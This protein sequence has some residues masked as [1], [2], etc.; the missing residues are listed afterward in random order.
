MPQY[1]SSSTYNQ[2]VAQL[3]QLNSQVSTDQATLK[4]QQQ[5]ITALHQQIAAVR[6]QSP[7][8]TVVQSKIV[9]VKNCYSCLYLY[10]R[11]DTYADG[12]QKTTPV[13]R[14]LNKCAGLPVTYVGLVYKSNINGRTY[15]YDLYAKNNQ[16]LNHFIGTYEHPGP[17]SS[18]VCTV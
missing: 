2:A 14:Q 5:Q 16:G 6:G 10:N 8:S 13:I 15:I 17:V 3:K 4:Q 18:F 1:V 11:I 12:T 7:G 9:Y